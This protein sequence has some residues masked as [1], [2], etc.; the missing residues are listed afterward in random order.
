MIWPVA[1][2]WRAPAG[3]FPPR[4]ATAWGDDE[5]GLWADLTVGEVSQRMRWI[6]PTGPAGFWMG[7]PGAEREALTDKDLR[8]WAH[9]SEQEPLRVRVPE[10]FWLADTPCTQG[11]WLR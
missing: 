6:E 4:W 11:L 3:D 2:R 9:R 7:S 5:F 8:D 10:G 1:D